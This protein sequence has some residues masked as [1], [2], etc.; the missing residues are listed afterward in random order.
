MALQHPVGVHW[1]VVDDG[2]LNCFTDGFVQCHDDHLEF[3]H[4][5]VDLQG[6]EHALGLAEP[7]VWVLWVEGW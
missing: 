2:L 6:L 5:V 3:C 7:C 1:R 4:V